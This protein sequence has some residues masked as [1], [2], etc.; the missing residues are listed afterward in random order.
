MVMTSRG[1]AA[2]LATSAL[3][4]FASSSAPAL[5]QTG[6]EQNTVDEIV[7]VGSQIQGSK[8]TAALPV[9]LLTAEQIQGAAAGSGDELFRTIPQ[10]G[11]VTFNSSFLPGS[12]NSARGDVNSIS[13]RN[14][15]AGNT[16]VLINGRRTVYH[17]TTQAESLVPTFTYNTNAI[18]VAGLKSIE[19]LRDG[20]AAIY[21][22][23]AV[24]GVINTVLRDDLDG[25]QVEAQYGTAPGANLRE[26]RLTGVYGKN[27][28][29]GR[30]NI[31]VFG[32][33]EKRSALL[34]SDQDYTA[35]SNRQSLFAGTEFATTV[36]LD[37]RAATSGFGAFQAVGVTSAIRQ[38][39]T[40]ITG[41]TGIFHTSPQSVTCT[42][43]IGPALCVVPGAFNTTTDRAFRP[44]TIAQT[45][46]S[47]IPQADRANL[48]VTGHYDI[49]DD[50]TVFGEAGYYRART[51]GNVSGFNA[52]T[53]SPVISIGPNAFFNPFG[54]TT[55]AN[56]QPN[57]NRLANLVGV[58]TTGLRLT[59]NSY[60]LLDLG[61]SQV[62]VTND[63]YRVLGGLKGKKFGFRW[64]SAALY[65]EATV[66]DLSYALN[67]TAFSAAVNRTTSD[68]YNPFNGIGAG[69]D[70]VT[71]GDQTPSS[72]A[73]IAGLVT[74]I[75]RSNKTTLA[76]WDLKVSRPD[77]LTIWAGDIGLAAGIEVR[78]E[79]YSDNRDDNVDG[80]IPYIDAI[81][82]P[83]V[84]ATVALSNI[85]GTSVS[86]D[87]SGRRTVKSAY[88]ELAIPLV[89]P[90]MNIPLVNRVE[91]QLAG[92]AEDYSD[93]GSVAKPKVAAAWDIVPGFRLRGSW[94]QGFKA[95]NLEQINVT[96]VSRTNNR[97]DFY[98]CEADL[99]ARRI[100]SFTQCAQSRTTRAVRA[101]NPDLKPET[102]ESLSYGIVFQ[103]EF[104]P[105]EFGR[106]ILTA[107]IWKI[108]QKG[109][110]GLFGE[111]NAVILDYLLRLQG[112]SNPAVRR[113]APTPDNIAV[114]A[115]TG[116]APVGF[117]DF[118]DDKYMNQLPQVAQG[119]DLGVNY[120]VST[121]S[122]GDFTLDVNAARL[123][124]L[125]QSP[126]DGLATLIAARAAG[127]INAGTIITGGQDI[128]GQNGTPEWRGTGSFTWRKDSVTVNWFSTYT[129][130]Y[131][132][133]GLTYAAGGFYRVPST[134]VHNVSLAYAVEDG[135]YLQGTRL[136]VGARNVFDKNPPLVPG[137][138]SATV[139]NP[140]GRYLYF[141]V[142]KSF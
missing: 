116:L 109:I 130:K 5:A 28:S 76:L 131:Y 22:T 88:A 32:S 129:G 64:E 9:T 128:V 95:P 118:A 137:G 83:I 70:L 65:S 98:F 126:T 111:G 67:G 50:V 43:A 77:L 27:F 113:L 35:S 14:L 75:T 100:T 31:T 99:R 134:L 20:A 89:S 86:P 46:S 97:Q 115:G 93:V 6:S 80:T 132:D 54:A 12:S 78:R 108:R 124:K 90:E 17:P 71:G 106:L 13:L 122:F 81:T 36:G 125:Y 85:P 91:V 18:P 72:A 69:A 123:D 82:G 114:F 119:I 41:S 66:D 139:Y 29:E 102:S 4:A 15:G 24:A 107:D 110:V 44:D 40:A 38:G 120:R 11:N 26:G 45:K 68:A 23:D 112:S 136:L 135:K 59:F 60:G 74:P 33:L 87:V 63:Q 92:R 84:G 47:V 61:A 105:P 37:N 133:T 94:S 96:Q 73:A 79:T 16:L 34:A 141:N 8:V 21:G 7:V 39:T 49:N 56:G 3:C 53:T 55:L 117:V 138:F 127:Q 103:P 104:L 25:G 30:G 57:P 58:P 48:F 42:V 19:V 52:V 142:K 140:Y 1:R 62:V 121:D 2:L 51:E 10:A 101:G